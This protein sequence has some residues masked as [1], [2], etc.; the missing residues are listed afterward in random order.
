MA[1]FALCIPVFSRVDKVDRLLRSA[2]GKEKIETVHIADDG[3]IDER[4][5]SIYSRDYS[6]SLD[7]IDLEY[8]A[9]VGY[10]HR[11]LVSQTSEQ[12]LMFLDS[13]M[14]VPPNYSVLLNQLI[15]LPNVGGVSG[16]YLE[17]GRISTVAGDLF[18][19][20][21]TLVKDIRTSKQIEMVCEYPFARFD[22]TPQVGV[23]QRECVEEYCWD[24]EYTIQREHVDFFYGH[25]K[26][27]DWEFGVCPAVHIPHYPGG[28]ASYI[29]QRHSEAKKSDSFNYFRNKWKI[30]E[31]VVSTDRWI[32]TYDAELKDFPPGTIAARLRAAHSDGGQIGAVK[33]LIWMLLKR[34]GLK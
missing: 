5:E 13:D 14:E 11:E 29:S 19:E 25:F 32:D 10:K 28:N 31:L 3:Y 27:T 34:I 18:V 33:Y 22:Y 20:N 15:E 21:D 1:D 2:D 26:Y 17:D 4:K 30:D 24:P 6:F 9:G 8:D 12:Y 23:F 7:M 16:M